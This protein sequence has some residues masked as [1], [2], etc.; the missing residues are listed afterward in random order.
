[1]RNSEKRY[2]PSTN[3]KWGV[4]L[5]DGYDNSLVSKSGWNHN[6]GYNFDERDTDLLQDSDESDQGAL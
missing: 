1:M 5:P 4:E 2:A 6:D 3:P